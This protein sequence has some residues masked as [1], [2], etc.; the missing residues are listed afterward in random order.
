MVVYMLRTKRIPFLGSFPGFPL[1][2]LTMTALLVDTFVPFTVF[3]EKLGM[4][5]LPPFYFLLILVPA[6][7]GYLTL[8]HFLKGKFLK[9]YGDLF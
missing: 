7:V 8:A 2:L 6:I 9:R 3:G 4:R 5:A 1:F